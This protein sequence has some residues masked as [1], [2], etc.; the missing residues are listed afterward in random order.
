[1]RR[2][3]ECG[4]GRGFVAQ[5]PGVAAVA[6]CAIVDQRRAC[7]QRRGRI[8]DCRQNFVIDRNQLGGVF[9]LGQRF[10][11]DQR[12]AVADVAHLALRQHRVRRLVHRLAVGAG[13]K[14]T[15]R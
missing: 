15:A 3:G 10:G 6:R 1:M 9:C 7:F 5:R 14:P 13:D 11:D 2:L 8:D 12:H 4:V